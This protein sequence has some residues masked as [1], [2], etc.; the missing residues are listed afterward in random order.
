MKKATVFYPFLILLAL[1]LFPFSAHPASADVI[2]EPD[3]SFYTSHMEECEYHN[4]NYTANKKAAYYKKPGA[5]K[6]LGTLEEGASLWVY[7][8]YQSDSDQAWGYFEQYDTSASGWIPMTSL[9]LVYD[10]EEFVAEHIAELDLSSEEILPAGTSFVAWTYPES[11]E[12]SFTFQGDDLMEDLSLQKLYTDTSGRLWGNCGYLYGNRDFWICISD[13]G[14]DAI[15]ASETAQPTSSQAS[16]GFSET[17]GFQQ[18][19]PGFWLAIFL[20]VAG[21]VILTLL[22]LK[23]GWKKKG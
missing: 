4:R 9:T 3:D 19:Q 1:C 13:P 17:P 12:I 20:P 5:S 14:N 2:W 8:L 22:L 21:V 16:S 18:A 10:S 11:G 23:H 6:I 15:P 7:Y